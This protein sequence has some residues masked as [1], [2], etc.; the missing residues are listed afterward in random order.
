MNHNLET[1][2]EALRSAGRYS[3]APENLRARPLGGFRAWWRFYIVGVLFTLLGRASSRLRSGFTQQAFSEMSFA[4]IR[5]AEDSGTEVSVEGA[6]ELSAPGVM[7]C[8][9]AC[10]HSSLLETFQLPCILGAFCPLSIVAKRSL[11]KYPLFGRCLRAVDP[12]LLD[13][14]SARHDLVETLRQGGE[15]LKSGRSVLLFPQ[16]RRTDV[17]NPARFN[18]LGAKLAVAAGVPL[19]PVA[20]KTDFARPGRVLKDFGPIDPLRPIRYA[21]GKPL[22]PTLPQRE[23]QALSTGFIS[24]TLASWGMAVENGESNEH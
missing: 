18:S 10:N 19:V 12:I 22:P 3:T 16:G 21:I 17:F 11:A 20:C 4:I 13:R 6:A 2:E 15:L 24:S 1:F 5:A 8:V 7:P 14:K 9:F 23:L